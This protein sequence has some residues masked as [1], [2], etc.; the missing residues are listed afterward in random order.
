M[1]ERNPE[2][3]EDRLLYGKENLVVAVPD[4]VAELAR[5]YVFQVLPGAWSLLRWRPLDLRD[6]GGAA[7]TIDPESGVD[8]QHLYDPDGNDI[9]RIPEA[10][11]NRFLVYH[12]SLAVQQN[13]I[14]LYPL[15][16]ETQTAGGFTYLAATE[17][18]PTAG[19]KQ[20]YILGEETNFMNP[21]R[22]LEAISFMAGDTSVIQYGFYN[23]HPDRRM[24]PRM[25]VKGRA[26]LL[27][28][29]VEEDLK[30]K[31]VYGKIPR[32]MVSAGPIKDSFEPGVPDA[33]DPAEIDIE[34][35]VFREMV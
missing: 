4:R 8:Y 24:I 23:E 13:R 10:S 6:S 15:I 2:G 1:A 34:E 21:P 35:A 12:F 5:C 27:K 32:T 14:R 29:V 30:K 7:I 11:K 25:H 9:L 17:P 28:P 22:E 26:Y 19:D 31:I 3:I 33:W 18:D 20:G 16:P